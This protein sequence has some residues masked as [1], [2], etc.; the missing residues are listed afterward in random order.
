[1][2]VKP[3]RIW[4]TSKSRLCQTQCGKII[5]KFSCGVLLSKQFFTP[6]SIN[7]SVINTYVCLNTVYTLFCPYIVYPVN[8]LQFSI[9]FVLF[10]VAK[11]MKNF[12]NL[13]Y[14]DNFIFKVKTLTTLCIKMLEQIQCMMHLNP[15]S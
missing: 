10:C 2:N 6:C 14:F 3:Q 5:Y 13:P 9:M 15:R 12:Q 8:S 4:C 7:Y 11:A 1:M